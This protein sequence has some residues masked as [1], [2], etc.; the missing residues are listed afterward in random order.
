MHD[1][2]TQLPALEGAILGTAVGDALGLAYEGLSPRRARR[3][4]GPPDRYR[5]VFRRGMT[6][7][8]TEH[9]CMVAQALIAS[10][11]DVAVFRRDLARRM[12]WWL[13]GA[14]AGI[15]LAT[16]K[17]VVRL[18]LGMAPD[19]SGVFSAGN[20]PAMRS[21][22][23]GAAI[24]DRAALHLFVRA[25]TRITHTDPKAED[26]A[27]TVAL[28]ARWASTTKSIV[29]RQFLE[30]AAPAL[31]GLDAELRERLQQ[32]AE[33]VERGE[34]TERFAAALGLHRGVTGYVNHTVPVAIHAWLSH[35]GDYRS[36]VTA[37]IRCGG[38][39]DT[40][41]A[42]VG[43]IVGSG[44]GPQG[45]PSELLR[46]LWEWPRSVEWMKRLAAQLQQTSCCATT[47]RP[48]RLPV[49]PLLARNLAFLAIVLAHG[50]RRL[51]PP[52]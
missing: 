2:T 44:T 41:A 46:G 50:L 40:T 49:V 4:L 18:W 25:S 15:G 17:S 20:G 42:I 37:V 36:A 24:E 47:A 39:A 13:A 52:Y 5:F 23:L 7:D 1:V 21:A 43:G 14:P 26:G 9:T 28:A 3:M 30:F 6:S 16:L 48:V 8:D 22:I 19:R 10:G 38:D 31:I 11:A 33:S 45:I 34:P 12:R 51:L 29:P 27:M 35:A 32:A